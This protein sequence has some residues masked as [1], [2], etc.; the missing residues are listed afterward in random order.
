MVKKILQWEGEIKK[1]TKILNVDADKHL[2]TDQENITY[3]Y[4]N[5]IWAAD[6]K[7]LYRIVKV[8]KSFLKNQKLFEDTKEHI[9]KSRGGDSVFSLF[10]EVDEPLESFE[11]I[12]N[13]HLFYTPSR[14]GLGQTH[15]I[16]LQNLLE[17]LRTCLKKKFIYG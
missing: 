9:F 1:E 16:D 3:E 12:S 17:N 7:T 2:L 15:R 13:G 5:L 4:N 6:L 11:K 8:D 10:L 14:Q